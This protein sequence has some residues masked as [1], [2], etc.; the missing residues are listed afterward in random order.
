[1]RL[2]LRASAKILDA[3]S[4]P[5][6]AELFLYIAERGPVRPSLLRR[7]FRLPWPTLAK[8]LR[9]LEEAGL[10]GS[11]RLSARLAVVYPKVRSVSLDLVPD[12]RFGG[13][14]LTEQA[15]RLLWRARSKR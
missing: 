6:R 8:R 3:L 10:V 12:E 9:H 14:E 15:M 2:G 7:R 11:V 13:S 4:D 5:G 1:V